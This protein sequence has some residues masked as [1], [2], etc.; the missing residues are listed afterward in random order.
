M[1]YANGV[2]GGPL[3]QELTL[4]SMLASGESPAQFSDEGARE[5]VDL[6]AQV[7]ETNAGG[8]GTAIEFPQQLNLLDGFWTLLYS[9]EVDAVPRGARSVRQN[10]VVDERRVE[11][12]FTVAFPRLPV[13]PQRLLAEIIIGANFDVI[14]IDTIKLELIDIQVKVQQPLGVRLRDLTPRLPLPRAGKRPGPF[15][16][17]ARLVGPPPRQ[18]SSDVRTTYFGERLRIARSSGGELRIFCRQS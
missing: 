2:R 9:S 12:S 4:L 6:A 3:Q 8:D 15:A 14:T 17:F 7:L 10:Y 5:R 18:L 13:F 11:N 16:S 1:S